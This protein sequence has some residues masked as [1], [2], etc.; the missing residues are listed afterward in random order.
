MKPKSKNRS[1]AKRRSSKMAA[2]VSATVGNLRF[3]AEHTPA[4]GEVTSSDAAVR[5]TELLAENKRLR[6]RLDQVEQQLARKSRQASALEAQARTDALTGLLNRRAFDEDMM[7]RLA[8]WRRRATPFALLWIDVDHFKSI[9]D[10]HGHDA[11]DELLQQVAGLLTSSFRD[12]DLVARVGG[13]EF[14]AVLPV[15]LAEEAVVP[16]ERMRAGIAGHQFS[17]KQI[18]LPV[19]VSIG[20][21]A[22]RP[23]D[24]VATM[25]RRADQSL[26]AAKS[27]GRNIV[28]SAELGRIEPTVTVR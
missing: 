28:V 20:V 26:Y 27:A 15:T 23:D 22:V 6:E 8:A 7:R 18:N 1:V 3:D 10:R 25:I 16:A 2:A 5:L 24:D 21:T 19:T 12:M 9:N 17:V 11:G 13:E 14:A 4:P